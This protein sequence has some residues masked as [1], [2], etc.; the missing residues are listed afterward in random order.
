MS[1]MAFL[2]ALALILT[3]TPA[4]ALRVVVLEGEDAVNIVQQKTAVRPLVEVRDRNNLPVPGASVTFTVGA[5]QP[6]AFGGGAQTITVTTNA[7][8]QAAPASFS[9]TGAGKVSIQVQ[10]AHQGQVASAAITQT[11]FATVAAAA[12]AGVAA[13]TVGTAAG[14]TGAGAAAGAAGATGAAGA[15]GGI[16]MTTIAIVGGAVAG[17]AVVA[18]QTGVLGGGQVTYTGSVNGQYVWTN[19]GRTDIGTAVVCAVTRSISGTLTME[20]NEDGT[21]GR[22]A[23]STTHTDL[24]VTAVAGGFCNFNPQTRQH[25]AEVQVGGG[26]SALSFSH[27]ETGTGTN[28]NATIRFAFSGSLSGSTI[29]GSLAFETQGQTTSPSGPFTSSASTS[30]P[31]TLQR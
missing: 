2:I 4:P 3:Q 10:A 31:V 28:Q 12:A 20:L 24:S 25:G 22:A 1:A 16:S 26:P 30:I 5:G 15:G 6:A 7:A 18:Q 19:S 8:G 14:S 29:T 17:G 21:S 11:N 23:V 9:A 13:T 27:S